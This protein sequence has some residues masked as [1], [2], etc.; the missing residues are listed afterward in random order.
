MIELFSLPEGINGCE[1]NF[2]ANSRFKKINKPTVP[3]QGFTKRNRAMFGDIVYVRLTP[4]KSPSSP[5]LAEIVGILSRSPALWMC[6]LIVPPP[7]NFD[8]WIREI[9]NASPFDILSPKVIKAQ[10]IDSRFPSFTL[11]LGLDDS[12]KFHKDPDFIDLHKDALE[13]LFAIWSR[14]ETA[15]VEGRFHE[16]NIDDLHPKA[17]LMDCYGPHDNVHTM[18]RVSLALNRLDSK[19]LGKRVREAMERT[20]AATDP[21]GR[22]EWLVEAE[23]DVV[24]VDVRGRGCIVTVD[25]ATARDL[26]DAIGVEIVFDA[27]GK[28]V[29]GADITVAVADVSHFVEFNT[30]IDKDA[31]HRCT[32]IYLETGVYPMLPHILSSGVCSL[33]PNEDRLAMAVTFRFD[34]NGSLVSPLDE[35]T[36]PT[37]AHINAGHPQQ[38]GT[39]RVE[40]ILMKSSAR[41]SYEEAQ[42]LINENPACN[43]AND[44]N[45]AFQHPSDAFKFLNDPRNIKIPLSVAH[46]ANPKT[47][48][49]V[50]LAARLS[51]C[52][53]EGQAKSKLNLHAP[54]SL[55]LACEP[56]SGEPFALATQIETEKS[57]SRIFPDG[58]SLPTDENSSQAH[59]LIEHLMLVANHVAATRLLR[60]A[61]LGSLLRVHPSTEA[62]SVAALLAA[63]PD[64]DTKLRIL[65]HSQNRHDLASLLRAID[66]LLPPVQAEQVS[67]SVL[68]SMKE[69]KYHATKDLLYTGDVEGT[70]SANPGLAKGVSSI[71]HWGVN[72]PSYMH[73]TSPIRRYPDL[74]A[75]RIITNALYNKAQSGQ[76]LASVADRCNSRSRAANEASMAFSSWLFNR[77]L[78]KYYPDG[79]KT[80]EISVA[81]IH[82]QPIVL[83]H[84]K[85][86]TSATKMK[87]ETT[88][89]FK[90][91]LEFL[92]RQAFISIWGKTTVRL[93]IRPTAAIRQLSLFTLGLAPN[94]DTLRTFAVREEGNTGVKSVKL[95]ESDRERLRREISSAMHDDNDLGKLQNES[96][97]SSVTI[98]PSSKSETMTITSLTVSYFEHGKSSLPQTEMNDTDDLELFSKSIITEKSLHLKPFSVINGVLVP[99]NKEWTIRLDIPQQP[100]GP[101]LSPSIPMT[102]LDVSSSATSPGDDRKK[103][104]IKGYKEETLVDKNHTKNNKKMGRNKKK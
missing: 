19:P 28:E 101:L 45:F 12:E 58:T 80:D 72:L 49:T 27:D 34:V 29:L 83:E 18:G 42:A 104:E 98:E 94:K 22:P 43:P 32:S 20:I 57:S 74:V 78:Q 87:D 102:P 41:F 69:A 3:L 31:S 100:F 86:Y 68:T 13:N 54:Q 75:H 95:G 84:V 61:P 51:M 46:V 8:D 53:S 67:M 39:I 40:K 5:Y 36:D 96:L 17:K 2:Q 62:Q 10:H 25:P 6:P 48:R 63:L 50:L 89:Q 52:R 47:A 26:D 77:F 59:H 15:I 11:S 66:A 70:S 21:S 85:A 7:P 16:W 14:G 81:S 103:K 64:G 38:N 24:R 92:K 79:M 44:K 99:R 73:F 60:I 65:E 90:D 88:K 30:A 55:S 9:P 23:N 76:P 35:I 33:L 37:S 82:C 1:L 93:F 91:R 71:S 97:S 56:D 4:S